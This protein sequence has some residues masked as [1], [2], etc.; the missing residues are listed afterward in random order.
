MLF[1]CG[2]IKATTYHCCNTYTHKLPQSNGAVESLR[3][4]KL[5]TLISVLV[6]DTKQS[7]GVAPVMQELWRM[8]STP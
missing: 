1:E 5:P 8:Q 4:G 6:Y 3:G 7:D 2:N